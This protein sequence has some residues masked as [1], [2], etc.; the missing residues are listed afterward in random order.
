MLSSSADCVFGLAR[1]I[2]SPS[3]MFAKIEPGRNSKSPRS[4]LKT[5][6]PGDV[7]GQKV[8]R[9]LDPAERAVDRAGDRLREHRL[10]DARHVLDQDVA[11]GEQPDEREA[12]L[13]VLALHDLLDVVLDALKLVGEPLPRTGIVR[14][15]HATSWA[16]RPS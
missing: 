8:G 16:R 3:T 9:E 2:S 14:C 10:A 1:L 5:F 12:D 4:W 7:G 11:L 6:T 15:L 13:V